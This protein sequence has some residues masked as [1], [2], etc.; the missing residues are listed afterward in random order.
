MRDTG[1]SQSLLLANTLPFSDVSFTG[2]NVLIKGVDSTE[3]TSNPLHNAYLSSDLVSGHVVVGI[4]PSLPFDGVHL[5]LGNDL[6]GSKVEV[7][8]LVTDKPSVDPNT[9]SIEQEI[10][11]LFPSCAVTRSM[12]QSKST[13]D[14]VTTDVDL[15]DTF[16][17][18]MINDDNVSNH[19]NDDFSAK[20]QT[21]SRSD[22]I[23]EQNSD[24]DVSCLFARSV[25]ESDVSR[26]P[27][28]F[29]TKSDVLMRKWRPTQLA[30]L[31]QIVVP[32]SYRP[33]ILS[34]SHDTPM[35]GHLG[36]NKTYQRILEHFYWPTQ[37][38]F[39]RR[40]NVGPT[41]VI[42]LGQRHFVHQPNV[43]PTLAKN[44]IGP[45]CNAISV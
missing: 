8:P 12:T 40:A 32:S 15:A 13:S 23:R 4:L 7:N 22:L 44:Y 43:G 17:S 36:I 1:A 2:T 10:P 26:D 6:A 38:A 19:T 25:D 41:Y 9:D 21:F 3:F 33:H 18:R 45:T 34:L 24:P 16:L 39:R 31:R 35:S 29:Y 14:D 42:T 30:C 11:G 27:V 37:L 20:A 5:L 28:C